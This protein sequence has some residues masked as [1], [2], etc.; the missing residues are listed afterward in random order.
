M[1]Q[2]VDFEKLSILIVDDN[3]YMVTIIRTILTSFG[4]TK[5]I[6][7]NNGQEGLKK[8][9]ETAPDIIILDWEMPVMNGAEMVKA[10]R[11]EGKSHAFL[12]IIM[13]TAHTS[14][15]RIIRAQNLG[16][17]EILC[18]PVSSKILFHRINAIVTS[19]RPFIKTKDYFGPE[20]RVDLKQLKLNNRKDKIA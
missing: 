15:N 14:Q 16:V 13:L 12:P 7:A 17:N 5:I 6:E 3:S 19:P 4:V 11:Q 1:A 18:K 20:P 9:Y 10:I 2:I 8:I